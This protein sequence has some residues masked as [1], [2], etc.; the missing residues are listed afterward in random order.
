MKSI[1][2][3]D[4]SVKINELWDKQWFLLTSGDFEKKHFNTM[5]VSWGYY[6]YYVE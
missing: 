3:K 1:S 4:F 5:T 2:I 6:G